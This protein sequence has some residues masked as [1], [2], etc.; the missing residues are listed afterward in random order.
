MKSQIQI[1]TQ[2]CY[3]FVPKVHYIKRNPFY[4]ICYE[5]YRFDTSEY[6]ITHDIIVSILFGFISF[7]M[8]MVKAYDDTYK[9]IFDMYVFWVFKIF[10]FICRTKHPYGFYVNKKGRY[11]MTC[12]ELN[13]TKGEE[14]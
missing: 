4:S 11:D 9:Y 3:D 13:I 12:Y 2:D 5:K 6:G 14:K 10:G 8:R 7:K 1:K